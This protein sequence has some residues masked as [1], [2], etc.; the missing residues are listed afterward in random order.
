MFSACLNEGDLEKKLPLWF[1]LSQYDN[2]MESWYCG[3]KVAYDLCDLS[4]AT[5]VN[6]GGGSGAGNAKNAYTKHSDDM[7]WLRLTAY[8]PAVRGAVTLFH[9]YFCTGNFG[10][11]YA[12]LE[13]GTRAEYNQYDM[14]YANSDWDEADSILVPYGT[15]VDLYDGG[16]FTYFLGTLEGQPWIDS[17]QGSTCIDLNPRGWDDAIGSLVVYRSSMGS[18]KGYWINVASG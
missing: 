12:P 4:E 16:D 13:Y 7:T 3:A 11:F 6:G 9:D 5:C 8:D 15:S 14:Q 10:R 1:G 2:R 17:R 18:A